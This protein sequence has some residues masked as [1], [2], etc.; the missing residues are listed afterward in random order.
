MILK[1]EVSESNAFEG[2]RL[3]SSRLGEGLDKRGQIIRVSQAI[4][5]KQD[6][7]LIGWVRYFESVSRTE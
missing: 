1:A 3:L 5:D 2:K 6:T 7:K 4:A